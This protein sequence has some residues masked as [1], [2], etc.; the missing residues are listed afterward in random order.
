MN[1]ATQGGSQISGFLAQARDALAKGQSQEAAN[2]VMMAQ[3]LDPHHPEIAPTLAEIEQ[4]SDMSMSQAGFSQ[5]GAAE[6]AEPVAF[7]STADAV[8]FSAASDAADLFEGADLLPPPEE[9]EFGDGSVPDFAPAETRSFGRGG[10]GGERATTGSTHR[11][12]LRQRTG[13]RC[14]EPL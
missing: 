7:E 6:P 12:L 14:V 5:D 9:A 2:F 3:A 8:D 4:G 11:G 10:R 13:G 1:N